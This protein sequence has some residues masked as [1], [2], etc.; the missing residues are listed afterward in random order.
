MITYDLM[1]SEYHI[2]RPLFGLVQH[3]ISATADL[4][5]QIHIKQPILHYHGVIL[6]R[7]ISGQI[8]LKA[9]WR[10][11]LLRSYVPLNDIQLGI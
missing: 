10:H 3:T 7:K 8:P 9:R 4:H 6:S 2:V 5:I 11:I 1:D